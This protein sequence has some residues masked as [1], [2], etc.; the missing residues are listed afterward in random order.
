MSIKESLALVSQIK[1]KERKKY[2]NDNALKAYKKDIR[3]YNDILNEDYSY[4]VIN[5][6]LNK[7]NID[8]N[9]NMMISNKIY[10]KDKNIIQNILEIITSID[11][12]MKN[13]TLSKKLYKGFTHIHKKTLDLNITPIVYK[14][15][16]S[17]TD[18]YDT[19]VDFANQN[20][21]LNFNILLEIEINNKNN[22]IKSININE[23]IDDDDED[24]ILLE[25]NT[26]FSNFK[27]IK[28]DDKNKVY[29]YSTILSKY[30]PTLIFLPNS[31]I[32][33]NSVFLNEIRESKNTI[34]PIYDI[35]K[36]IK[37]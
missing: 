11:A 9:G 21:D 7:Y 15:F 23:Y 18:D 29:V 4:S 14:G 5:T 34:I 31:N 26:Q 37:F 2:Y 3:P 10:K 6:F 17:I 20:Q 24:E 35:N 1:T 33:E 19:A 22:I 30:T 32:K 13:N 27:F 25:R 8:D 16:N 12:L 28:Y 36:K